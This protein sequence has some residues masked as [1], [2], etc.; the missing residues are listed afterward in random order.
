[1]NSGYNKMRYTVYIWGFSYL[2]YSFDILISW[3]SNMSLYNWFYHICFTYYIIASLCVSV[4]T[5]RFSTHAF[6]FGFIDTRELVCARHLVL[7]LP[8][9]GQLSDS[10]DLY[11]QILKLRLKWT[12]PS[13]TKLT[14]QRRLTSCSS[15]LSNSS[16]SARRTFIARK[17]LFVLSILCIP[18]FCAS[19]WYN[20]L[21]TLC[22][23][24]W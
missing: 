8:L 3:I 12:P 21:V 24:M 14:L 20:M 22:H 9:V 19:W 16:W 1:M 2:N 15:F 23:I 7:I 4:L 11:V 18:Y 5:T 17:H 10:L 6:P 13:R